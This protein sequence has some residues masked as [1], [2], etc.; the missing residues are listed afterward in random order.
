MLDRR[1][2]AESRPAGRQ[3]VGT[4][5]FGLLAAVLIVAQAGLLTDVIVDASAGRAPRALVRGLAVL[6]VVVLAAWR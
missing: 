2:F 3:L 1:L 4:V 6:L 5:L